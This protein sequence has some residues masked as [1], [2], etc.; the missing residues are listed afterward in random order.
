VFFGTSTFVI[1]LNAALSSNTVSKKLKRTVSD[2]TPQ[3]V[4]F[5]NLLKDSRYLIFDLSSILSRSENLNL[6]EKGYN[7]DNLYLKQVNFL[8]I[9]SHD[10]KLPVMIKALPG[11]VRDVKAIRDVIDKYSLEGCTLIMNRG[12]ASIELARDLNDNEISFV[13]PLRRNSLII[14]YNMKLNSASCTKIEE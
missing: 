10:R 14:D 4:F 11:S 12:L 7:K 13:F 3:A 6:A 8:L 2:Y 9:F 1:L 5:I